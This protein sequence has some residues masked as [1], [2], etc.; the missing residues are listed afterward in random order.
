MHLHL[1]NSRL[2][3]NGLG[4]E[5]IKRSIPIFFKE[6]QLKTLFC[7]P[8]AN[9]I[10]PNKTLIKLRF[11]FIKTYET[12]PGWINFQQMVNRYELSAEQ[13]KSLDHFQ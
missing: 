5:L 6:F 3:K 12:T 2:R 7:E 1:W 10:A 9:N 13:L 8:Y 11:E 4:F